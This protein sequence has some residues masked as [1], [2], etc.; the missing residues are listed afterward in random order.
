MSPTL[1]WIFGI[2]PSPEENLPLNDSTNMP[3]SQVMFSVNLV[4]FSVKLHGDVAKSVNFRLKMGVPVPVH[5]RRQLPEPLLNRYVGLAKAYSPN[6]S[7][8]N[9]PN[10]CLK[11]LEKERASS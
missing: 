5:L 8:G 9:F 4:V 3:P 7:E 10:R 1:S 6:I 2:L 11:L